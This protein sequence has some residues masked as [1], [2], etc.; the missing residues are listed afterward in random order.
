MTFGA[1][2]AASAAVFALGAASII[3]RADLESGAA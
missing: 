3:A 1:H 2:V